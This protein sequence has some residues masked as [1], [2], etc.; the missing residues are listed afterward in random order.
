MTLDIPG[1]RQGVWPASA[2]NLWAFHERRYCNTG[3]TAWRSQRRCKS[4]K[5]EDFMPSGVTP[6]STH[7]AIPT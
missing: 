5:I 6:A 7:Y 4:G 2:W 3:L 1:L